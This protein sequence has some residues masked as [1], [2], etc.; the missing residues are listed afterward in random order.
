M[1]KHLSNSA[2]IDMAWLSK[3]RSDW[4]GGGKPA[5]YSRY[6]YVKLAMRRESAEVSAV[7]SG[8]T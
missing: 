8:P 2:L 3:R 5:A 7:P 6:G 1:R 4:L